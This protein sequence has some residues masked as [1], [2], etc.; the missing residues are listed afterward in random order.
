MIL[1]RDPESPH[2]PLSYLH[3]LHVLDVD[4]ALR[5]GSRNPADLSGLVLDGDEDIN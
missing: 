5:E 4:P 2:L 1:K 3:Q